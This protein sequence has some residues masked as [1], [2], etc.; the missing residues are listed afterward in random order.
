MNRK[1]VTRVASSLLVLVMAIVMLVSTVMPTVGQASESAAYIKEL[2]SINT[3]YEKYLDGSVVQKLP[4]TVKDSDEISVIVKLDDPA[5]LD[6]YEET[7]KSM[8]IT[9]FALSDEASQIR[10]KV[11]KERA[12]L[13]ALLDS[14]N[15]AYTAGINYDTVITGFEI[16]IKAGD[17][18]KACDVLGD[19]VTTIVGEVYKTAET[20]LVN[21]KVDYYENT[22]IFNSSGF[23]YDGE[24]MVVA[25]LDTGL[26]YNHSAFN[27]ANFTSDKLGLTKADV[28]AILSETE[29]ASRFEG[30]AT[31]DV[32]I[33]EKV[34]FSFDYADSDADVYSMHNNHGTHVSGVI[35]GKD[36][37]ITGVAPNAQLVSMKI[38]S[39]V[40]DSARSSWI[41]AALEDC[42][43]LGVDVI[44]M[45]LG[46]ACGFSREMDKEL[47]SG[48]Y[49]RI[50]EAGISMVVAASNSYNSAY[51]SEKN[52]NLGLTSNPDT[53]TVGSPSTYD[54]A[55]SVASINGEKTPYMLYGS[56]IMYFVEA[57]NSAQEEKDFFEEIIPT[58]KDS[59]EIE[60]ILVPGSGR[61]TDYA[62]L[63]MTGKIALV[64]RGSNTFEEKA[65]AAKKAGAA[66]IIIYNNVAGDIKMNAGRTDIPICSISQDDG[67]VLASA[68]Q[69]VLKIGRDQKSGPF[70]SDFSSWG[71]TPDL[72][73]KP[74]ITAHGGNILSAVTANTG[75][76]GY[77]RLSGTSMACPNMA[78]VVALMRQYVKDTF[79]EIA[80]DSVAVAAMVN[81][82]LMSTADV[83]LNQNGLPYAVR[84][85]GAGLA[86]LTS[87]GKTTAYI[88]TYDREDGSLMDKSKIELGDDPNKTGVYTLRFDVNNFGTTAL[89]YDVSAY[90]MT[91]GVSETKTHKGETTVT[92]EG[93][94]LDG[95]RVE[96]TAMSGG[97]RNGMTINVPAGEIVEV[98][99]TITLSD[100]D[101]SYLDKSF[102]NGMYVEGFVRLDAV[103]GTEVS[104][105][106]PYLAF[107]GDWTVAPL[108]DL[109]YFETNADELDDSIETLDKTLPDAYATRPI[110]GLDLDYV[111]Y[112]GSYYFLQDP[113]NKVISADRNYV[114]LSNA[115]GTVHSLRFVW[116]GLLRNA[117]KI[118]IT[119][120]DDATGEVIFET[121]DYDVR[122][123]YGDGGSIYPANVEVEFD[124]A[125]HNL[126]NN[127]QY[128]VKLQGY[129]DYGNGGLETNEKSTFEFPMTADFEAPAVT[130]C[131]F[132]T[133]YDK[134][135]EKM[136][137]F[138]KIAVYDNHYS[139]AMQVGYITEQPALD[140]S[141]NSYMQPTLISFDTYPTPIYAER[142][143]TNYVVYELT[144]YIYDIKANSTNKNA[145]TVACYDYALNE[146]T[147]E[148]PLPDDFVDFYFADDEDGIKYNEGGYYELTLSPNEVYSLNPL[149]YPGTEWPELLEYTC[150]ANKVARVVN[151]R[152]VA[153]APG[154]ATII[155]RSPTSSQLTTIRVT[156]LDES[157]PD[158]E[159]YDKPVADVFEIRGYETIKAYYYLSN[160]ER[161]IGVNG[162]TIMFSSSN[163][164]LKMFPS[165]SVKLMYKLD[166]FFPE[167]TE[168]VFESSNSA[169]V[170]ISDDGTIVAKEEGYSSVTVRLTL[171][172][173]STYYSKTVD[174]EVKNPYITTGPSLTHYF[175]NGGTVK[176][177]DDLRL[178]EIGAY[179]FSNYDY[180]EKGENDEISEEEP[181][182][183]KQEYLGD[184]TIT[185][186]VIPEGVKKIGAYAFA[187][188][189]AL[190]E[191]VL[192]STIEA[193]EYGAFFGCTRLSTVKGIENVQLINKNAF[194]G[195]GI[196]GTL[197]LD[198]AHAISDYAFAGNRNIAKIILGDDLK[199]VGAYAFAGNVKVSEI[200][201]QA[202]S[203]KYG[204]Y[205]FTGC[206]SLKSMTMN[207]AVIPSGAFSGCT[208]LTNITIGKDVSL[209]SEF[210][211][212]NTKVSTF[213]VADG[214]TTFK[215]QASGQYLLSSDGRTL[216]LVS[217]TVTGE[218][219]IN[220]SNVVYIGNGAFSANSRI[221]KVSIPSVVQ[222]GSY[223]FYMCERLNEVKLGSLIA[224]GDYAFSNTSISTLPT[225]ADSMLKIGDY[226]FSATKVT[227]VEIKAN[228]VVG[229]GAFSE[230][231]NIASIV[232]G[233]GAIIGEGAFMLDRNSS[234]PDPEHEDIPYYVE[235][236]KRIY[237]YVFKSSLTSLT[238]G[239]DVKL[240]VAAFFGATKLETVTLGENVEIGD[241]AF[242]NA[243]ELKNI[244]LSKVKSIGDLAFSGDVHYV[245]LDNYYSTPYV[246]DDY[247]VYRYYAPKFTSVDLTSLAQLGEQAFQYCKELTTVTLGEN[248][249]TV[250]KDAFSYC[251][252]LETV[253]L[254]KVNVI[255]DNAF[256]ETALKE[257][258]LSGAV[259]VGEYAFVYCE[260]LARVTLSEA[261]TNIGEG[262]FA[263]CSVL[264]D[265]TNLSYSEDIGSYA[266]A[267]AALTG[268]NL[269][270]A[271]TVGDFAFMKESL[272]PFT[273]T[274]GEG[275]EL[276]GDNPF[277]M[278]AIAPFESTVTE[279]FNGKDYESVTYTFDISDTVKV[280]DGSLYCKVPYGLELI[281]YA[282]DG[283]AASVAENTVRITAMAFAGSDVVRVSL[284]YTLNSIGHKAFYACDKL[285]TVVFTSYDAPNLEE[286]FDQA[287]HDNF[288]SI[289]ATGTYEFQTYDGTVVYKDGLAIVPYYM[290][291]V[292][293]GKYSNVYYGANFVDYVGEVE[294]NLVMI[295]PSNGKDYETFIYGQYF[296][297]VIEGALAADDVTLQAIEAINKLPD[298]VQLR[299]EAL[300]VAARAAYDR[301]ATD[302]QKAL[303]YD[304][305]Q[306]LTR[307]ERRIANFKQEANKGEDN[308]GDNT[309]PVV[310]GGEDNTVVVII[311][312]SVLVV[313][314]AAAVLVRLFLDKR[315]EAGLKPTESDAKAKSDDGTEDNE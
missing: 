11:Y 174:V 75:E 313:L 88:M 119:I 141:G 113:S 258:N 153:V 15:V 54:G 102:E 99:V 104:L 220:D 62:G 180:V 25:V 127:T 9:E 79:P 204:P 269:T 33:N 217:P 232:I 162:D 155:V 133:E 121:V 192:P 139:M 193:I 278:C 4:E 275:I 132:Y 231:K 53:G 215:P 277:A 172:G 176:I 72:G 122:K 154:Q 26:D 263:Y 150:A 146:A 169:I 49:D 282:G 97:S 228:T 38:F 89:S 17:F 21:N 310:D 242:Y 252:K 105:G 295:R 137:L 116:A 77:D 128:S 248:L 181:D 48:V 16:L 56:T 302:E 66:G 98:T 203:V 43:I 294:N 1:T 253:N 100:A 67:E 36:D 200:A 256:A 305:Y 6:A 81:R 85:Q 225:F 168:V 265:V 55:L 40:Q 279:T 238:V 290:W 126:K 229:E 170:E 35:V 12:R 234:L 173:G 19:D 281:T 198:K 196:K 254:E 52:G 7:D 178:T 22:G 64:R 213:T 276:L 210:A 267:Y 184:A 160:D 29:A 24:G 303:I 312:T 165:E 145:F 209:I 175:G 260:E 138:A 45:S 301:I 44:N 111:N 223:A 171:D 28:A 182:F 183:T 255:G 308:E 189:T 159:I 212:H 197:N 136:R 216:M 20:K 76:S 13:L 147:Y 124:A 207:T 87:A 2:Q 250:N 246:K 69:G 163:Y 115:S 214:N 27:V 187:N 143:T 142:D 261:G 59:M 262:A 237:Y 296:G 288:D 50:R 190:E 73:I 274:L 194:F 108:F 144:D 135:L 131:E 164:L 166:A 208:S 47:E 280:I 273:V 219:A 80:N 110:G 14:N 32:Y 289:P 107:Y 205:V 96:I 206:T 285:T 257:V 112:L 271:R 82:L 158:Y 37:V 152:V 211:F 292:S 293:G 39:D 60:Y 134:D 86:N 233:D 125:E 227:G 224:V 61:P 117:E 284:P 243:T 291:N 186:V 236:G 266:F 309:P 58:G 130:G 283:V 185:K 10:S 71:P 93:Y 315:K 18:E 148:I 202:D 245:F 218:F 235:D 268:A 149:A 109:D 106:V 307:A 244:D 103:S 304:L 272:T 68:E 84:K 221:T 23:G 63:D 191:V 157:H 297:T 120:T 118:V 177:P 249:T 92:E 65:N 51:G 222:V 300:V 259:T 286:E 179:A 5:I 167:A 251:D 114:A 270:S 83:I 30:L 226:A 95:A 230:C 247:Y 311:V 41:L 101:K 42:V 91:E 3:N 8:T 241:R 161:D 74:E 298:P 129:L 306:V 140:E 151:N 287:R 78:G 299:D 201:V 156:V 31:D 57:T 46:T 199:S 240:G 34:P 239:N 188:L 94:L 123:S 70:I 314:G 195:C 264:D 90:V